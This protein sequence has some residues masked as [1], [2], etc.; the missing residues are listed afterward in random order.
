MDADCRLYHDMAGDIYA[1]CAYRA[2]CYRSGRAP[3]PGGN[4][5]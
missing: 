2:F 1:V 3:S 5:H 4:H